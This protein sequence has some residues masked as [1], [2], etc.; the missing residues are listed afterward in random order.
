M[1]PRSARLVIRSA[2]SLALSLVAASAASAQN[3]LVLPAGSV[4]IVRTAVPL[5]S[6]NAR[7]GQTFETIVADTVGVDSY[8]VIPR[9]SRIQGVVTLARAATRQESG[10]MEVQFNRLTLADGTTYP[11]QASLTSTDTAERRQIESDPNSRVVLVGGRGGIGA[12]IAGAG[13]TRSSSSSILSALGGLLSEGR[14]VSVPSGTTLAVQLEQRLLLRG[15]GRLAGDA[16]T[17]YTD[18]ERIRAAQ[19]LL[20]QQNY[21]RGTINGV[22]DDATQR[23]LFEFQADRNIV[24]TGNLD[25]RTA[26]A[27]GLSAGVAGNVGTAM[28]AADASLLRRNAQAMTGRLRQELAISTLGR[29]DT[30]RG[31]TEADIDLWF[32]LSAFADNA[33]LYEQVVRV[34]GN[35]KGSALAGRALIDAARRVDSAFQQA[36]LSSALQ[37]AWA[38]TRRQLAAIDPAYAGAL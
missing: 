12:A 33:S 26:Q 18:A 9:G 17:I 30:Q 8:S 38:T 22:L 34:S 36:R 23:A 25:G 6:A 11:I 21:Y 5:E 14:N 31:Y 32:A 19:S 2:S 16:F 27:L 24:P 10:V 37:N 1:F 35:I 29:L 13:S 7:V 3:R 28:S 20:A 15:R 4:I